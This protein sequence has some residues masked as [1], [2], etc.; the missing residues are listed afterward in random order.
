MRRIYSATLSLKKLC[1]FSSNWKSR[2]VLNVAPLLDEWKMGRL[3]V[4]QFPQN[5]HFLEISYCML[6]GGL[7]FSGNATNVCV[8]RRPIPASPVGDF[9][10]LLVPC[11][12]SISWCFR[13]PIFLV[14]LWWSHHNS[15]SSF[16]CCPCLSHLLSF[17]ISL[18]IMP[19]V[20]VIHFHIA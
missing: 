1:T 18:A 8:T 13:V 10:S 15:F 12:S 3:V 9:T 4:H 11:E 5:G 20:H 2:A 16:S 14:S 17:A 6:W 7:V 19:A